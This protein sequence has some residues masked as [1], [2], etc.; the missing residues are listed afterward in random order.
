M[1][2]ENEGIVIKKHSSSTKNVNIS[3]SA[4][5][6]MQNPFAEDGSNYN[7]GTK[8]ISGIP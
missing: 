7:S 3:T 4:I 6:A 8:T 5:T 1:K 2:P